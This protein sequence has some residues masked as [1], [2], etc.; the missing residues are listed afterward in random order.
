M[1]YTL[2]TAAAAERIAAAGVPPAAARA[3]VAEVA[4]ADASIASKA[5]LDAVAATLKADLEATVTRLEVRLVRWIV[6][7]VFGAA[8][9]LFAAMRFTA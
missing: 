5:D 8:G 2:D 4:R 3:I 9:L 6:V 7:S 1:P